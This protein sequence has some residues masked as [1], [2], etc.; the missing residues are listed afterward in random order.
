MQ[1]RSILKSR[2]DLL[3]ILKKG[4]I[5]VEIGVFQGDFSKEI[6][7]IVDP[8]L[9][10]LVDPWLGD[11]H[12][13]DENGDNIQ[14]ISGD[15]CFLQ[16][17]DRFSKIEA[18]KIIRGKSTALESYPDDFLDWGYIDGDHSFFGVS[19]DIQLLSRKVKS[20]GF[21]LGH[22]YCM[23]RFGVVK[24]VNS[25]CKKNNLSIDLLTSG[26]VPSWG[27]RNIKN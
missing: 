25:F 22:D 17:L 2:R 5:G 26:K 18:V 20:G 23:K 15:L 3:E 21:I 4:S 12:S 11:L 1:Q 27:I 7:D 16:I 10:I 14:H 6:L 24:A 19:Y 9:L 8:Q 13:G